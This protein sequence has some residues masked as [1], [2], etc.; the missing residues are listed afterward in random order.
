MSHKRLQGLEADIFAIITPN[1]QM[2]KPEVRVPDH[3]GKTFLWSQ[4]R[5]P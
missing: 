1:I 4:G 2:R 3:M 5:T